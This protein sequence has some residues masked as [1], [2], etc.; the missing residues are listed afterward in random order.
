M[1]S[2]TPTTGPV[3]SSAPAPSVRTAVRLIYVLVVVYVIQTI[4]AIAAKN[5]LVAA[6][7]KS[8]HIATGSGIGKVEASGGAPAYVPIAVGSLIIFGGLL[9]L[10]AQ[11]ISRRANWARIAATVLAV[12]VALGLVTVFAQPSP[13]WYK[14]IELVAGLLGVAI[15]VMLYRSDSNQFFRAQ[16]TVP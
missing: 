16:P 11:F 10:C 4:L 14:L 8:Q 7:A 2:Q 15:I 13:V 5:S 3:S 6:Y 9:V 1:S 12:L